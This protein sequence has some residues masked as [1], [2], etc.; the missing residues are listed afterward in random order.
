[1][2]TRGGFSQTGKRVEPPDD[3][4]HACRE[5]SRADR[6]DEAR[7]R[8]TARCRGA[9][10]ARRRP[11]GL[12]PR[13]PADRARRR[14]LRPSRGCRARARGARRRR[15]EGRAPARG[16]AVEGLGRR[17]ADRPDLQPDGRRHRR[18]LLRARRGDRGRGSTA[19]GRLARRR[20]LD[21][22]AGAERAGTGSH[23]G[24]RARPL[25]AGADRL[26]LRPRTH[27]R[28]TVRA[29]LL[30]ARRRARRRRVPK[31]LRSRRRTASRPPTRC[32]PRRGSSARRA[33]RRLDGSGAGRPAA[34]A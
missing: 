32:P 5:L 18:R 29:R 13:R 14:L 15:D 27:R 23:L 19:A 10:H 9:V 34:C 7:R 24:A 20:P 6:V 22:A 33:A 16:L 12:G 21:E 28:L 11:R 1:M 31:Q 8:R 26:G 3:G 25:A 17:D 4:L 30:H 2:F